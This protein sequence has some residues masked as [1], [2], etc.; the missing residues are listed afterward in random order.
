[1]DRN[2]GFLIHSYDSVD[3]ERIEIPWEKPSKKCLSCFNLIDIS[4]TCSFAFSSA[5]G[6]I[7]SFS[8]NDFS[9]VLAPKYGN[10]CARPFLRSPVQSFKSPKAGYLWYKHSYRKRPS[11]FRK[12]TQKTEILGIWTKN[13]LCSLFCLILKQSPSQSGRS[14]GPSAARHLGIIEF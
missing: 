10:V 13:S 14:Y 3:P 9:T 6:A 7:V 1:M 11:P 12:P 2:A 8:K 4:A 5:R